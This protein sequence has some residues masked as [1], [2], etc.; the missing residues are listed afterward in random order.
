MVKLHT[1]DEDMSVHT[2]KKGVIPGPFSDSLI[3]CR[4][5]TFCEIKRRVVAHIVVEGEVIE[6]RGSVCHVR[7]RGTGRPH[8]M[9]VYEATTE[10][11]AS[12]AQPPYEAWNPIPGHER[13]NA[14]TRQNFRMD[15]KELIVIPNVADILKAPP[16]TDK[17]LGPSKNT[18]CE[19]NQAFGHNLRNCLMLGF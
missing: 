14:P 15:L 19:F 18:W 12:G 1:K 10:K 9:R 2:F 5:K 3:R 7:T 4:P 11:K 16:K 13:E 8:P 6:K 17:R